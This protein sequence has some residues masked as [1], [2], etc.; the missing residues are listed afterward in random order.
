MSELK[1]AVQPIIDAH[2]GDTFPACVICVRHK[3]QIV[4]HAAWGHIDPETQRIP[5][6]TD[7][8]FDLASVSKL[9]SQGNTKSRHCHS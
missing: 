6:M 9:F 2:L 7:T 1:A 5:V 8:L 4:L 3:G